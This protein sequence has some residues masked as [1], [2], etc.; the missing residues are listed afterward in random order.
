MPEIKLKAYCKIPTD[1]CTRH[2]ECKSS[3]RCEGHN[4]CGDIAYYDEKCDEFIERIGWMP[5][6]YEFCDDCANRWFIC[7][8]LILGVE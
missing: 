8:N 6:P 4:A 7:P 3:D 5:R 2:H 1:E